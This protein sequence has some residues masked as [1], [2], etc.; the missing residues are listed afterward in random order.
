M[1]RD[2]SLFGPDGPLRTR[3]LVTKD[4]GG[5]LVKEQP[6]G[7][8]CKHCDGP[9]SWTS[10]TEHVAYL[11]HVAGQPGDPGHGWVQCPNQERCGTEAQRAA[12]RERLLEHVRAR[13][14]DRQRARELLEAERAAFLERVNFTGAPPPPAVS[15]LG[16]GFAEQQLV[17]TQGRTKPV[18]DLEARQKMDRFVAMTAFE[19][20]IAPFGL[21]TTTKSQ[22][23]GRRRPRPTRWRPKTCRPSWTTRRWK[24]A[25]R[26]T[27]HR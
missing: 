11:A 25:P 16:V 17:A 2:Q 18:F 19:G 1:P 21:S 14:A 13:A 5:V 15:P 7:A 26:R 9:S 6:R 10:K 22:R 24:T 23:S 12:W 20:D 3:D 4:R 27:R 8:Q